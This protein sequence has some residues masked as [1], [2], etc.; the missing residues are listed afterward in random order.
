MPG[1]VFETG[2]ISWRTFDELFESQ[3]DMYRKVKFL[4]RAGNALGEEGIA[5]EAIADLVSQK[6]GELEALRKQALAERD[7]AGGLEVRVVPG[8]KETE[9]APHLM[10][11]DDSRFFLKLIDICKSGGAPWENLKAVIE[12]THSTLGKGE[13]HS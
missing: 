9:L 6:E 2:V 10:H 7:E 13:R 11:N 1:K 5:L 3:Y 4:I 8:S 12:G